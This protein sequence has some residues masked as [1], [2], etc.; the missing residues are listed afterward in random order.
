MPVALLEATEYVRVALRVGA[1]ASSAI[2]KRFNDLKFAVDSRHCKKR[3]S[4]QESQVWVE[5]ALEEC[6]QSVASVDCEHFRHAPWFATLARGKSRR[7]SPILHG[8]SLR[9]RLRFHVFDG[10]GVRAGGEQ[11]ARDTYAAR[12]HERS[13]TELATRIDRAT[14]RD[15]LPHAGRAVG[16]CRDMERGFTAGTAPVGIGARGEQHAGAIGLRHDAIDPQ[17]PMARAHEGR[18]AIQSAFVYIEAQRQVIRKRGTVFHERRVVQH[19]R[20]CLR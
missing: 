7:R 5:T 1:D 2:Q 13:Q 19:G 15:Q 3:K 16:F 9:L 4:A 6:E 20:A 14:C 8:I 17:R 12:I 11:R 10:N 18:H